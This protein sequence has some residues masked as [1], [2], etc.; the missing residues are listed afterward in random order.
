MRENLPP[1]ALGGVA[2]KPLPIIFGF[3]LPTIV[4]LYFYLSYANEAWFWQDDFEFISHYA[5]S[6]RWGQLYD[7]SNFGR[8]L[9]RN[10]YWHWGVKYFSINSQFFYVFNFFVILCSSFLLYKIFERHGRFNAFVA[11]LIYFILPATIESYS[12]LSNSQHLL[13]HFF[14]LLFVYLFTRDVA[15][16]GRLEELVWVLQLGLVLILGLFSNIFVS[17]VVSLPVW[18]VVVSKEYRKSKP[19]YFIIAFGVF[20]FVIFFFK[21]SGAQTGAYLTSYTLEAL[22]KNLNFYLGGGY[23]VVIWISSLVAGAVYAFSMKNY[24]VSW[25]F[26]ASV[27]FFLPFA[28]FQHQRYGQYGA[29]AYLFFLLGVWSL[30]VQSKWRCRPNLI[31]YIGLSMVLIIFFKSLEPAIRYFSE[32]P[33]GAEQKQQVR[34]LR[35]FGSEHPG[36]KNYC[37]R[38]HRKVVNETGVKEWDIPGD[39]WFVGF[40]KAFTLFVSNEKTYELIQDAEHCDAVFFFKDGR[41]E[42]SG[43]LESC[44]GKC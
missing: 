22:T 27:A 11:G 44:S 32:N 34:F 12:W 21:L 30:L 26:L 23:F 8:F 18:M 6:M 2:S 9:S 28:F 16:K 33:R 42:L 7:F 10:G 39:W 35:D 20:L 41:L 29:L 15:V 3:G 40:G 19:T 14:V 4:V 43:P 37:F 1:S 13:G 17:M 31:G 38:S 25:L 36:L 24:F 5:N